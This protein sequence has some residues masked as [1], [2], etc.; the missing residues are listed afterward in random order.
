[1]VPSKQHL[2][3]SDNKKL[4]EQFLDEVIVKPK[5]TLKKWSK[6]TNQTPA[7][8]LGYIGQHLA[9]LITGIP[10]T[11][12]GA[13]GDDLE[14]SSEVKSCNKINQVDKCTECNGRVMR[15]EKTC[16]ACGSDKID[17]KDDSK[18]LFSIR[19]QEELDQYLNMDRVV[20]LLMDYPGFA[21][22]NFNDIRISVFEI[23]P[24]EDRMKVFGELLKNHY[25]NIYLPKLNDNEKTNPMNLH[26]FSYQFYKCNPIL[27]FSC[28]I[29]NIETDPKIDIRHYILPDRERDDTL[30]SI[31][32]PTTLL[33]ESE[34]QELLTKTSF[35]KLTPL[36]TK[37]C[38]QEE[39]AD[40]SRGEKIVT[41]PYITEELRE[42][43]PLR[44]IVSVRQKKKYRRS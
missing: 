44:P 22:N 30:S 38:T 34:W 20:L 40:L 2:K 15:Y 29:Y 43:L 16:S 33:K 8:K 39:F 19:S 23:Y 28:I 24:K 36:M 9:S 32:M 11:G 37:L 41:L 21:S 1:M 25:K 42:C 35:E 31:K 10:G 3:I 6:I 7:V 18:W 5:T 27:T 14:D 13:R 17:R 4:I 26:P 12:S